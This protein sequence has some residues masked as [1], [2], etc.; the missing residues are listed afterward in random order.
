MKKGTVLEYNVVL[1]SVKSMEEKKADDSVKAA[2]QKGTDDK[3]LQD[4]FAKSNIHPT[5]TA[6]GL[7]YTVSKEGS[8]NNAQKGQSVTVNYTGKTLYWQQRYR[9]DVGAVL[10]YP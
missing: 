5:K 1:V 3:L 4:Y 9:A 10:E 7:Y 8:G 2:A 6:S